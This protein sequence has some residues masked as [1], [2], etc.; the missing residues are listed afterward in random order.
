MDSKPS[1]LVRPR[2]S[3]MLLLRGGVGRMGA[4]H[5]GRKRPSGHRTLSGQT[6]LWT[7]PPDSRPQSSH[8]LYIKIRLPLPSPAPPGQK[9]GLF[10]SSQWGLS[11]ISESAWL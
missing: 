8:R 2:A 3:S 11:L 1:E 5:R 4:G 10:T 7:S 9:E 6:S